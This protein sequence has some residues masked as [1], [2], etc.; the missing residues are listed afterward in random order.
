MLK[1]PMA[2][3]AA[4]LVATAAA[5]QTTSVDSD[6]MGRDRTVLGVTSQLLT[7][8]GPILLDPVERPA[9]LTF[10]AIGEPVVTS[11]GIRIGEIERV[12]GI[13]NGSVSQLTV[14]LDETVT[15][16]LTQSLDQLTIA[17]GGT[18]R[19]EDGLMLTLDTLE[20]KQL[21]EAN[22]S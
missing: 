15:Q 21:L 12:D 8:D 22:G 1:F 14:D 18:T 11:D 6:L 10:A 17:A 4:A 13:S 7:E 2:L 5:A 9:P 20:V 16:S 19:T 3:S